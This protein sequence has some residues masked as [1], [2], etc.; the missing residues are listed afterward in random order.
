MKKNIIAEDV[1]SI[2]KTLDDAINNGP[3][4]SS[5]F[6]RVVGKNLQ[7]IRDDL[8]KSLDTNTL[9]ETRSFES[10]LVRRSILPAE[11]KKV[12]IALYA[13]GGNLLANWE[14]I[15]CNLSSQDR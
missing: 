4:E 8:L 5:N 9:I 15:L 1:I 6:L 3:W 10:A 14:K 13:V 12:F 11:Q 7:K 2:V